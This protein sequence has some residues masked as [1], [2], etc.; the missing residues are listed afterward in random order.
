MEIKRLYLAGSI[1]N[2]KRYKD[3]F[4]RASWQLKNAG[5]VVEN[6]IDFCNEDW[7]WQECMRKCI[8]VLSKQNAIAVIGD[9]QNS[10]GASL[11]LKIGEALGMEI[12]SVDQWIEGNVLGL[13]NVDKTST[14]Q[15]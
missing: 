5:Y 12:K 11:E 7:S 3:E 14:L 2:N 1:T 9:V 10:K 8:R 15:D 6:P 13:E 4:S